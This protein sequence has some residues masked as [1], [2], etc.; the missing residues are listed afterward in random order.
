M[1]FLL[2][3]QNVK[4]K[5]IAAKQVQRRVCH[6]AAMSLA[7]P[8]VPFQSAEGTEETQPSPSFHTR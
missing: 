5:N 4:G 7:L 6:E 1:P 8:C 3:V 2:K